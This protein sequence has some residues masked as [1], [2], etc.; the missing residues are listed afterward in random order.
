MREAGSG[1]PGPA[2]RLCGRSRAERSRPRSPIARG[3]LTKSIRSDGCSEGRRCTGSGAGGCSGRPA[4]TCEAVAATAAKRAAVPR[5]AVY[6]APHRRR[7]LRPRPGRIGTWNAVWRSQA[8]LEARGDGAQVGP[9][10]SI[11]IP[12]HGLRAISKR[13]TG[14]RRCLRGA[15]H[16]GAGRALPGERSLRNVERGLTFP[17]GRSQ[18]CPEPSLGPDRDTL[19]ARTT[20]AR[21]ARPHRP[22]PG[23]LASIEAASDAGRHRPRGPLPSYR[24]ACRGIAMTI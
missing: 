12:Q 10:V 9:G 7:P 24:P 6:L 1:A 22:F 20:E 19:A 4:R 8:I 3:V 18:P 14:A 21:V 11:R 13:R 23:V 5:G 2:S 16:G 15:P 17:N